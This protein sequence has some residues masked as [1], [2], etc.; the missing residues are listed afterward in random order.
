MIRFEDFFSFIDKEKT[1][2]KFNINDDD[3]NYPAW[4]LL[5]EDDPRWLK[6]NAWKE[7]HAN[8]NLNYAKYLMTFAQY[9]A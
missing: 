7:K 3:V 6:M 2:V 4:E 9:P 8:H 5:R 1:K